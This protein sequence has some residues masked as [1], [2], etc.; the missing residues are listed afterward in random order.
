MHLSAVIVEGV[1]SCLF[2]DDSPRFVSWTLRATYVAERK[3]HVTTP[4]KN[5]E[6][7]IKSPI[8]VV[9]RE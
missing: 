3:K 8:V 1:K 7:T 5:I 4:K 9:S 6:K 2:L